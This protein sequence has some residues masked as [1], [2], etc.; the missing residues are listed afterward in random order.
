MPK[1]F[2]M[3][4]SDSG[5]NELLIDKVIQK[6]DKDKEGLRV[7]A[8]LIK[9]R[10]KLQVEITKE[11][12]EGEVAQQE[13]EESGDEDSASDD[14]VDEAD[15]DTGGDDADD[16]S[17]KDETTGANADKDKGDKKDE[18][19]DATESAQD[20]DNLESM[21]GSAVKDKKGEPEGDKEEPK[22]EEK[23]EVAEESYRVSS[24]A[25][26]RLFQGIYTKHFQHCLA[27]E[28]YNLTPKSK[29]PKQQPIAYV[30]DEVLVSLK[31]MVVLANR[32]ITKNTNQTTNTHKALLSLGESLTVYQQCHQA[33]K[34]HLT[35]KVV[36]EEGKLKTL[37]APGESALKET[38]YTLLKYLNENTTLVAK[39]LENDLKSLSDSLVANGYKHEEGVYLYKKVLPGFNQLRVTCTE[40]QDYIKT[41]YE[42]YQAYRTQSY[43]VQE[44]YDLPG[45]TLD[46]DAELVMVLERLSAAL[47]QT[48]MMVDNLNDLSKQYGGLIEKVKATCYDIE[49]DKVKNLPELDIDARLKDFI[50]F[51]IASELCSSAIDI[52]VEY[53]TTAVDTF[54]TFIELDK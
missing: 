28:E 31:K 21:V 12:K 8:D 1:L 51:K 13:A 54:S 20:A 36:D 48:A 9:Q 42:D 43:K 22:S 7:T 46:K 39:V 19:E 33:K 41:K 11:L 26:A 25:P 6:A 16:S 3:E 34:L 30:K 38:S 5:S 49:Q 14:T 27:M 10:Q 29:D 44:L 40:Y 4:S 18:E 45:L 52:S 50:R 24:V 53:V 17:V 37:C 35:L 23:K 2:A 15:P 47:V 32:Y